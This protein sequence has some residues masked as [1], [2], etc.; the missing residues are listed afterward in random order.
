VSP[1]EARFKSLAAGTDLTAGELQQFARRGL[2]IIADK[3]SGLPVYPLLIESWTF[4]AKHAHQAQT[5]YRL[6][7]LRYVLALAE[8]IMAGTC[9]LNERNN[10]EHRVLVEFFWMLH[11]IPEYLVQT[12]CEGC[13][14]S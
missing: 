12:D 13:G 11:K 10:M 7:I 3:V 5:E 14:D 9:K 2:V 6:T 1:T 8:S 4:E